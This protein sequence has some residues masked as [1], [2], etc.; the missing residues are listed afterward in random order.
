[1]R[2]VNIKNVLPNF[3]VKHINLRKSLQ[4]VLLKYLHVGN[5]ILNCDYGVVEQF[6]ELSP[7]GE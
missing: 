7:L 4:M 5:L 1:M 3:G 6:D 2:Q